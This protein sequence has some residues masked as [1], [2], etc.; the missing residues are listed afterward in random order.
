MGVALNKMSILYVVKKISYDEIFPF[1]EKL[2]W[3]NRKSPIRSTNGLTMEGSF[4]KQIENNIPTFF[5]VFLNNKCVAVNSGHATSNV[6]YRSRGIYVLKEYRKQGISQLLF[7]AVHQQAINEN[8][9]ILWSIPRKQSI[10]AYLSFGFQ[11]I[12]EVSDLEFGPNFYVKK[13]IIEQN[14]K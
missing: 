6:E 5:G 9:K 14:I 12:K 1:W 13:N 2:L 4:N 7:K 11:I 10:Q 3:K 8:K